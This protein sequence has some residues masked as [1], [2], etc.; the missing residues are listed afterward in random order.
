MSVLLFISNLLLA[1]VDAA[2]LSYQIT[3]LGPGLANAINDLGEVAG[4]FGLWAI[5]L[6]PQNRRND[7]EADHWLSRFRDCTAIQRPHAAVDINNRGQ[8]LGS[9]KY[10]RRPQC[11]GSI[12]CVWALEPCGYSNQNIWGRPVLFVASRGE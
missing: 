11:R 3:D 8:I 9:S 10:H 7:P 2:P 12:Y 6:V 4:D 5:F 1:T